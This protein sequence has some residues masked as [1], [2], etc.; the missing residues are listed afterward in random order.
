MVFEEQPWHSYQPSQVLYESPREAVGQDLWPLGPA[1]AHGFPSLT[2]SGLELV[3]EKAGVSYHNYRTML[4]GL[5]PDA[6]DDL[7]GCLPFPSDL[8]S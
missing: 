4:L 3:G 6:G 5:T 8:L 2:L 7:P 1:K